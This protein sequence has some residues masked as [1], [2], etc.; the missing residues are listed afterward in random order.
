MKPIS[1]NGS[2]KYISY[3]SFH[4]S[5]EKLPSIIES[6]RTWTLDVYFKKSKKDEADIRDIF[7]NY[8]PSIDKMRVD[9]VATIKEAK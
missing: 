3:T 7:I 8:I 6:F 4:P 5:D 1:I 2:K 9:I